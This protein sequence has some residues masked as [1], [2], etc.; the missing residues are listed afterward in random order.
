MK[1]CIPM[2]PKGGKGL[3]PPTCVC[4]VYILG[5]P[6]NGDSCCFWFSLQPSWNTGWPPTP[7]AGSGAAGSADSR[8]R[9][10]GLPDDSGGRAGGRAGGWLGAGAEQVHLQL[11]RGGSVVQ[12]ESTF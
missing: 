7:S 10:R 1:M 3:P 5:N 8:T 12:S 6:K 2:Q 9:T 11:L 4:F